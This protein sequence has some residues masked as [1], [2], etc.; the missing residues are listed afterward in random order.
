LRTIVD[1]LSECIAIDK[2]RGDE[3]AI[4]G[5]SDLIDCKDVRVVQCGRR[6]RLLNKP[7]DPLFVCGNGLVKDLHS[8]G[9]IQL[10]IQRQI[11]FAHA[12]FG[13]FGPDF[14]AA[15]LCPRCEHRC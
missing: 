4:T 12:A 15:E 5:A 11:H 8:H 2:F 14:V 13:K 6:L 1:P 7:P 9:S 3:P 10:S